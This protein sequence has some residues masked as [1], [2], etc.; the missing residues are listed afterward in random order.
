MGL[1]DR[2]YT[3]RDKD[4]RVECLSKDTNTSSAGNITQTKNIIDKIRCFL[5]SLKQ[6]LKN[7]F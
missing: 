1:A 6:K 4:G 2:E 5:Q 7:Q 3:K